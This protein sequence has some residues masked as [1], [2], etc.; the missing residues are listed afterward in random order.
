MIRRAAPT[1]IAGLVARFRTHRDW[2]AGSNRWASPVFN[3]TIKPAAG[4]RPAADG[5]TWGHHFKAADSSYLDYGTPG[6]ALLPAATVA[7]WVKI[8]SLPADYACP[9]SA[10]PALSWYLTSSG[11]SAVY[12][13]TTGGA[14]GYDPG[15]SIVLS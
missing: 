6:I 7:F 2:S 5:S 9:F 10:Q 13:T 15:A 8:D 3:G 1:N 12:L 14:P 11:K 4:I